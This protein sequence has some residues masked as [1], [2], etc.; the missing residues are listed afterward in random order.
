MAVRPATTPAR[1]G[2][3]KNAASSR[4]GLRNR[5]PRAEQSHRG[6]H[7]AAG[8]L[9]PAPRRR[10]IR[11]VPRPGR[12]MASR[13]E[14]REAR[15]TG[16]GSPLKPTPANSGRWPGY[17]RQPQADSPTFSLPARTPVR[18][19]PRLAPTT[20]PGSDHPIRH[21]PAPGAGCLPA[22]LRSAPHTRPT[23]LRL[24]PRHASRS[25]EKTGVIGRRR[26]WP[27]A[28]ALSAPIH[29]SRYRIG[30]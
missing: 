17:A 23:A 13:P 10:T 28:G 25:S 29:W 21:V 5:S 12:T 20:R 16:A 1:C 24:A 19:P 6:N 4:S 22:S 30:A 14:G 11:L 2:S 9:R 27:R 8:R 18:P 26:S 3:F 7:P 15:R